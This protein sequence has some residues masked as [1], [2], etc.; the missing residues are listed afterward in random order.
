MSVTYGKT[1]NRY[2]I[3]IILPIPNVLQI[4]TQ[5]IKASIIK[6]TS[7]YL[8]GFTIKYVRIYNGHQLQQ[9][10]TRCL[11]YCPINT[12]TH[13]PHTG[14]YLTLLHVP[15]VH[16]SHHQVGHWFTKQVKGRGFSLQSVSINLLSNNNSNLYPLCVQRSFQNNSYYNYF[17]ITSHPLFVGRGIS[18]L[19]FL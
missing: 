13:T 8:T 17:T 14:V 4:K 12:T 6:C 16:F 18:L 19:L 1:Q 3:L 10:L 5:N 2:F 7:M 9:Q 15:A 11:F